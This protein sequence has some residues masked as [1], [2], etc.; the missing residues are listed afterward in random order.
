VDHFNRH[1]SLDGSFGGTLAA[2]FGLAAAD[3]SCVA[4][5]LTDKYC[6]DSYAVFLSH[7]LLI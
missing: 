3:P 4:V 7:A 1:D 5:F 2:I 6:E